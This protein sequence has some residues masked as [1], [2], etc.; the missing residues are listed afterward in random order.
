[1]KNT[2]KIKMFLKAAVV[3]AIALALVLPSSAVITSST[4]ETKKCESRL[5]KN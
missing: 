3:I 2:S 5:Y 1:M 4:T